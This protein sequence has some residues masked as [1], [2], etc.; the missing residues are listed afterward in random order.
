MGDEVGKDVVAGRIVTKL[1]RLAAERHLRDKERTDII[2]RKGKAADALN[3][4]FRP[5][6]LRALTA[7]TGVRVP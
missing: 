3:I 6:E 2:W 4:T 7:K 5:T 1:M